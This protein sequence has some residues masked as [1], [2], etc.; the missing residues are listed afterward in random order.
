M[1]TPF[2]D[3]IL[4]FLTSRLKPVMGKL[5]ENSDWVKLGLLQPF[6]DLLSGSGIDH[7]EAWWQKERQVRRWSWP[8]LWSIIPPTEYTYDDVQTYSGLVIQWL[9][10]CDI[11]SAI[12]VCF[13]TVLV[14]F[15][16]SQ[17]YLTTVGGGSGDGLHLSSDSLPGYSYSMIITDMLTSGGRPFIVC[18]CLAVL[19]IACDICVY[20]QPHIMPC[21][22]RA[23]I[24]DLL[25]ITP[26][27]PWTPEIFLPKEKASQPP[28]GGGVPRNP[29]FDGDLQNDSGAPMATP[30]CCYLPDSSWPLTYLK[31]YR[32]F[33]VLQQAQF[34]QCD[35][36]CIVACW[37]S[38]RD[39]TYWLC[40]RV[41]RVGIQQPLC[42]SLDEYSDGSQWHLT[43][44][45]LPI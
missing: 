6:S 10:P 42:L 39:T 36:M 17:W 5:F 33:I 16:I 3:H 25:V 9:V 8:L 35:T 27:K 44:L 2:S 28:C 43:A 34:S 41:C 24:A 1:P 32:P 26:P 14:A 45:R 40:G 4:A 37:K 38:R 18:I 15:G 11:A 7:T 21:C 31:P 19:W 13:W 23:F 30:P 29:T 12:Q 20:L 22:R